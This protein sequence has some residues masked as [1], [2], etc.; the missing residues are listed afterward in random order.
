MNDDTEVKTTLELPNVDTELLDVLRGDLAA[1]ASDLL[2]NGVSP[3]T[4]A[5]ALMEVSNNLGI[6]YLGGAATAKILRDC[7][8]IAMVKEKAYRNRRSSGLN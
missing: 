1:W 8:D 6:V 5:R 7:A 3:A 2:C 4:V